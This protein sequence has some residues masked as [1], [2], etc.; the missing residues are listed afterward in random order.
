M[1]FSVIFQLRTKKFWWMDVI[2]YFVVSL[3]LATVF[4]YFIFTFKN[5]MIKEQ[6]SQASIDLQGVGTQ[7]Q[8]QRETEVTVYQKKIGDFTTLLKNHEFASN[9]FNFMQAQTMPNI[10]F[11]Q[12]GLDAKNRSVQLNG[13]ANNLDDFSRQVAALERNKYI[14][15]VGS[16]NSSLGEGARTAFNINLVLDSSI[17]GYLPD[18]SPS[19]STT[20]EPLVPGTSTTAPLAPGTVAPAVPGIPATSTATPFVPGATATTEGQ[21]LI[22]SFHFLDPDVVGAI[23]Q[24]TFTITVSVPAGTDVKKLKPIIVT[25]PGT[26]V[27]PE[28]LVAEDFTSP[29]TY[30]VFSQDG[31]TQDYKVT[32]IVEAP[33]NIPEKANNSNSLI[34]ISILVVFVVIIIIIGIFIFLRKSRTKKI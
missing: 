30:G 3:L 12:F 17:F 25:S 8:K 15:S 4:C 10:W 16:F 22:N 31:K 23:D 7:Q 2:F 26:I 24:K 9:V 34:L 18:I 1:D 32:V 11:S 14:K 19:D 5:G 27:K 13:E 6:I 28:S 20:T 29:V 21:R 33:I